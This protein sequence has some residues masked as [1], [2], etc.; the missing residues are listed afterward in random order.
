MTPYE[1]WKDRKFL[2]KYLILWG[3]IEKIV[4]SNSKKIQ[5]RSRIVNCVF[6]IYTY[7]NSAYQFLVHKS[8]SS[9]IYLN[10][11]IE[12]RNTTFFKDMLL[13]K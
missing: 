3:Y 7:N 6:I 2:Y 13:F 10:I 1:L 9:N 12:S 11:I 8:N 4:V 5:I